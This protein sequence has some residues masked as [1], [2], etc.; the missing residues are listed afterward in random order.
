MWLARTLR[1]Y[2]IE[3]KRLT[4]ELPQLLLT[5][6]GQHTKDK[7]RQRV[8]EYKYTTKFTIA[9]SRTASSQQSVNHNAQL[10]WPEL[11][12]ANIKLENKQT[13]QKRLCRQS[14]WDCRSFT[15]ENRARLR[16]SRTHMFPIC[17]ATVSLEMLRVLWN[18][19]QN[20]A[21]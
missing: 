11:T 6:E 17:T 18:C 9:I 14:W 13:G 1:E 4:V 8:D 19:K 21:T 20:P 16:N 15:K 10:L 12:W 7:Y 3:H 5:S 2:W